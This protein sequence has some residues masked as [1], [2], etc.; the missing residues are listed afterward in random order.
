ME[1]STVDFI[2][3]GEM[4][5][6]TAVRSVSKSSSNM[7]NNNG[8]GSVEVT[9]NNLDN[10]T[11]G[12]ELVK[13][14]SD[15]VKPHLQAPFPP[16]HP[17]AFTDTSMFFRPGGHAGLQWTRPPAGAS[18]TNPY[19]AQNSFMPFWHHQAHFRPLMPPS[20]RHPPPPPNSQPHGNCQISTAKMPIDPGF[21]SGPPHCPCCGEMSWQPTQIQYPVNYFGQQGHIKDCPKSSF[22]GQDRASYQPMFNS[23]AALFNQADAQFPTQSLSLLRPKSNDDSGPSENDTSKAYWSD[24]CSPGYPLLRRQ[25]SMDESKVGAFSDGEADRSRDPKL[26]QRRSSA[27]GLREHTNVMKPYVAMP[28]YVTMSRATA[29]SRS[30]SV[31]QR[32][33]SKQDTSRYSSQP[34]LG[35]NILD[36]SLPVGNPNAMAPEPLKPLRPKKGPP[37]IASKSQLERLNYKSSAVITKPC[38]SENLIKVQESKLALGQQQQSQQQPRYVLPVSQQTNLI[39]NQDYLFPDLPPPPDALLDPPD[40]SQNEF[41]NSR[42][43]SLD[44]IQQWVSSTADMATI[45]GNADFASNGQREFNTLPA[46]GRMNHQTSDSS[47]RRRNRIFSPQTEAK[48]LILNGVV[49]K[50]PMMITHRSSSSSSSTTIPSKMS[51]AVKIDLSCADKSIRRP[52]SAPDLASDGSAD[53]PRPRQIRPGGLKTRIIPNNST[54]E[55]RSRKNS[56][57]PGRS[58]GKHVMFQGVSD[59]E[60]EEET[61]SESQQVA[62]DEDEEKG[63][64]VQGKKAEEVW[65]LRQTQQIGNIASHPHQ[66]QPQQPRLPEVQVTGVV[67]AHPQP[68]QPIVPVFKPAGNAAFSHSPRFGNQGMRPPP[69]PPP[70]TTPQLPRPANPVLQRPALL[71]VGQ[72]QVNESPDEGYHED[73]NSDLL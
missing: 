7:V 37:P 16:H 13:P 11:G 31:F 3:P 65:V 72:Q 43:S 9:V 54:L 26:R 2:V 52:G 60:E 30:N 20:Y 28:H 19:F 48:Q 71:Q 38:S 4:E 63:G 25:S 29:E 62:D 12:S 56:Q 1:R 53:S 68:C 49:R 44:D 70:R 39:Q 51:G 40:S 21:S 41:Q 59:D 55:R 34:F 32:S 45:S 27:S 69:P 67:I 23:Q 47:R 14:G 6:T 66:T 24:H 10:K 64:K 36:F 50:R 17:L 57:S 73:E 18:V 33:L 22:I 46:G 61:A 8:N 5:L 35:A 15:I 42:S 58:G